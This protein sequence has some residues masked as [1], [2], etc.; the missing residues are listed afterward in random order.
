MQKKKQNGTR[1][2]GKGNWIKIFVVAGVALVLVKVFGPTSPPPADPT[3]TPEEC[4]ASV[5]ADE[6]NLRI[7]EGSRTKANILH[8]LAPLICRGRKVFDKLKAEGET[9]TS[10]T[11][12]L[13]VVVEY[14][15]EIISTEVQETSIDSRTFLN[16]LIGIFN[17]SDFSFWNRED[18][19]AVFTY[20]ARFGR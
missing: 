9:I 12:T 20:T 17:M 8:D 10:G 18:V 7:L 4:L 1:F 3:T 19:D 2:P 5:Y 16:E 6:G 15:G 14:N 13:R 11:V